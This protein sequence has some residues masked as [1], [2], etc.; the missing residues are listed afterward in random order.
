MIESAV[1]SKKQR[2]FLFCCYIALTS[3]VWILHPYLKHYDVCYELVPGTQH[4]SLTTGKYPSWKVVMQGKS[5]VDGKYHWVDINEGIAAS[6]QYCTTYKLDKNVLLFFAIVGT[7][8]WLVW[9]G[10]FALIYI[11]M[12]FYKIWNSLE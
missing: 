12:G 3:L 9:T 10:M 5:N 11:G 6:G 1:V 4:S 8:I 7:S 2:A